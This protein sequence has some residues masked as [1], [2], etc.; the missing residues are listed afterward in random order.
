MQWKKGNLLR[1]LMKICTRY[2]KF[3]KSPGSPSPLTLLS[4]PFGDL[5]LGGLSGLLSRAPRLELRVVSASER[6]AVLSALS[7]AQACSRRN[8]LV[9]AP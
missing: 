1:N 6:P 9:S 3:E 5:D 2:E 7:L 8:I 4:K